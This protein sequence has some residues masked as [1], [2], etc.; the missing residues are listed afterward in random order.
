MSTEK[1]RKGLGKWDLFFLAIGNCIGAGVFSTLGNAAGL[2]GKSVWLAYLV[3]CIVGFIT[4]LPFLIVSQCARV[5]GGVYSMSAEL[6]GQKW[7]GVV[8]YAYIP[9]SFTI[10]LF[11]LGLG[12][13]AQAIFGWDRQIVAVI[14]LTAFFALNLM[15]AKNMVALQNVMTV[16]LIGAL[17]MFGIVGTF[18]NNG[19]PFDFG[20]ADYFLGGTKGFISAVVMLCFSTTNYYMVINFCMAAEKPKKDMPFAII[21]S[22]IFITV[23]Y[24]LA[25]IADTGVLPIDVIANQPLS[26]AASQ[27]FPTPLFLLFVIGGAAFA[28]GTTLNAVFGS[29]SYIYQQGIFDGW[30]PEAL[31]KRNKHGHPYILL[32]FTYIVALLPI[33]LNFD[34]NV[35]V[36]NILLMTY[37]TGLIPKIAIFTLP[38]KYPQLAQSNK[39]LANKGLFTFLMGLSLV[40]SV[41]ICILSTTELTPVLIIASTA[42]MALTLILAFGRDK[43]GKVSMKKSFILDSD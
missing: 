1:K 37:L 14:A 25:A 2:T 41:A 19:A 36:N 40:F 4:I 34:I 16:T 28:L 35:V 20:A 11:A 17:F 43:T 39:L 22:A 10:A 38:K 30:F 32:G 18:K 31:S 9:N 6:L 8:M 27:M 12:S 5:N 33:L 3:A 13:Y 26:V 29:F 24:C 21:L 23:L 7:G 15:P 42:A